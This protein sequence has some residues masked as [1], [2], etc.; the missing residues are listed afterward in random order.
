LDSITIDAAD[1]STHGDLVIADHRF[2]AVGGV[3]T[4]SVK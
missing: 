3:Y 2:A 4:V 1:T